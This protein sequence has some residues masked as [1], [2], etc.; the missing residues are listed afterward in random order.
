MPRPFGSGF[1]S[2][3]P[4]PVTGGTNLAVPGLAVPGLATP[5]QSGVAP[6]SGPSITGTWTAPRAIGNGR[7][8]PAPPTMPLACPVANTGDLGNGM[9]AFVSWTLPAG[10]L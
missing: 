6:S 7:G 1:A 8:S 9:I 5:G 3:A 2:P 4:P 10:Y